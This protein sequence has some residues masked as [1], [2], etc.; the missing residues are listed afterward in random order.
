MVLDIKS[1]NLSE[2]AQ[3]SEEVRDTTVLKHLYE[4]RARYAAP[5]YN[6]GG[7]YDPENVAFSYAAFMLPLLV[8]GNPMH[9]VVSAL[10]SSMWPIAEAMRLG[11]DKVAQQIQL[12][13]VHEA[14]ALDLL[15]GFG[16]EMVTREPVPG[17]WEPGADGK[18]PHRPA[19]Y[20]VAPERALLDYRALTKRECRLIGHEWTIDKDDLL[21]LA[22]SE[23]WNRQAIQAL[24]EENDRAESEWS[25]LG[26]AGALKPRRGTVH[27][28]D[29]WVPETGKIYTIGKPSS[30]G[31]VTDVI[32][33]GKARGTAARGYIRD[34]RKHYGARGGPYEVFGSYMVP[35]SPFPISALQAMV[36]QSKALNRRV[37]RQQE[38][39]EAA[40]AFVVVRGDEDFADE[41]RNNPD[42]T[43]FARD[44]FDNTMVAALKVMGADPDEYVNIQFA[45]D[46]LQRNLGY[47]ENQQ[48]VTTGDT[49]TE[50]GFASNAASIRLSFP[51]R[52]MA[53]S[54]DK[55]AE[56]MGFY[57]FDDDE[58]AVPLGQGGEDVFGRP[59]M[60]MVGGGKDQGRYE[61]LEI[62]ARLVS[63]DTD[64]DEAQQARFGQM[65]TL[66]TTIA[67]ALNTPGGQ[68]IG[69]G[70]IWQ[71]AT[72][73]MHYPQLEGAFDDESAAQAGAVAMQ[74]GAQGG[75]QGG[76]GQPQMRMAKDLAPG[77]V[78]RPQAKR[79][80][81]AGGPS[82][83]PSPQKPK[84]G[85]VALSGA[86]ALD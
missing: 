73:L 31:P 82:T 26:D 74:A 70:D 33:G 81:M 10:G 65:V 63:A 76:S 55:V 68:S 9:S 78:A 34:P 84:Q 23:G 25:V 56:K 86:L 79:Q 42:R 32:G 8:Y 85:N 20:R 24:V 27:L 21:D 54:C 51:R 12:Q 48:G 53:A 41:I 66:A 47:T 75:S 13:E 62:R 4:M 5:G 83:R 29:L 36:E 49:A 28:Y 15:F 16:M 67:G 11:L 14:V 61:D 30:M 71:E 17:D 57:I 6:S 7:E 52:K 80:P 38:L 39:V 1:Q 77:K 59:N 19:V 18:V 44:E 40:R 46:V 35:S 64:S 45:R 43:V 72:R 69:W 2:E 58:I 22:G 37:K 50:A 60:W 3:A